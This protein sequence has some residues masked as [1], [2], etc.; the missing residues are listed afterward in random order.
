MLNN[1]DHDKSNSMPQSKQAFICITINIVLVSNTNQLIWK[2][3]CV[4]LP[5]KNARIQLLIKEN[6]TKIKLNKT[7]NK[8]KDARRIAHSIWSNK[9]IAHWEMTWYF[10]WWRRDA[11][12]HPQTSTLVP[13]EYFL[14]WHG[15]PQ[16]WAFVHTSSHCIILLSLHLKTHFIQNSTQFFISSIST[17]K[18]INPLGFSYDI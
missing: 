3:E 16:A 2:V 17:I 10:C 13:L 4:S 7:A 14:G 11:S 12:G 5:H 6:K 18:I 15:H 1:I 9:N 8:N